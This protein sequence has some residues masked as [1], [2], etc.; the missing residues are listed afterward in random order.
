MNWISL[1]FYG[2]DYDMGSISYTCTNAHA[3]CPNVGGAGVEV[4][5]DGDTDTANIACRR[6]F[7]S[8]AITVFATIGYSSKISGLALNVST[9]CG[10]NYF[11]MTS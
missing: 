4:C 9:T 2:T 1:S 3:T 7:P 8:N 6:Y 5:A 11:V 10:C